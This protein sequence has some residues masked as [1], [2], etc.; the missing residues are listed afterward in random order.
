MNTV[1]GA[2]FVSKILIGPTVHEA[3]PVAEADA[4]AEAPMK[5]S[6]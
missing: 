3:V 1:M 6:P 5:R 2:N 4:C